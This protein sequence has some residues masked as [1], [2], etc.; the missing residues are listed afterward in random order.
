MGVLVVIAAALWWL[1]KVTAVDSIRDFYNVAAIGNIITKIHIATKSALL[2]VAIIP[3][4]F[5][6][7][8][9]V[10]YIFYNGTAPLT[11]LLKYVPLAIG[12]YLLVE[13]IL[14]NTPAIGH[15]GQ[16]GNAGGYPGPNQRLLN[17]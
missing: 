9:D 15:V 2:L 8:N 11:V 13:W 5:F 7:M 3:T 12:W 17:R 10:I 1:S 14:P 6:V 4:V 16:A